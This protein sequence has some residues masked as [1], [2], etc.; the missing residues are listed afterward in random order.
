MIGP[1]SNF[2]REAQAIVAAWRAARGERPTDAKPF[3]QD[4][5]DLVDTLRVSHDG[6][7]NHAADRLHS[8]M[9]LHNAKLS[10]SPA[11]T[12]ANE[13]GQAPETLGE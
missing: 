7:T 8:E 5:I 3:T 6:R 4:E 2:Q 13:T 1:S 12:Q 10:A 11:P 9:V